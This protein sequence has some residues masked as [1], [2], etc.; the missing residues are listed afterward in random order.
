MKD[1]PI[2]FSPAMVRAILEGR[3]T[4]TRRL[5]WTM[6]MHTSGAYARRPDVLE[7]HPSPW[8][9][10]VVGDWLW[11]RENFSDA[12]AR[13]AT[14]AGCIYRADGPPYLRLTDPGYHQAGD[15]WPWKSSQ[16]M[17]RWA[18]RITLTV[19]AT[20]MERLQDIS[21]ADAKAEAP[22]EPKHRKTAHEIAQSGT[23]NVG[24]GAQD[25]FRY[26][27]GSLHGP[28]AWS[29]NPEVVAI[30]FTATKKNIDQIPPPERLAGGI[31][32]S[33]EPTMTNGERQ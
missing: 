24:G 17:P 30:S 3:K 6:R 32:G 12:Y 14:E 25:D 10:V 2:I 31:R 22:P 28:D 29:A 15:D 16:R 33:R 1:R 27:W 20:K 9:K 21:E 5:A 26:L 4:M 8:Q 13:T 11:V 7:R 19:T 23:S 18:S